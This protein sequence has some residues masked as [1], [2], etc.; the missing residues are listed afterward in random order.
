MS[1]GFCDDAQVF[2]VS[3][4][5]WLLVFVGVPCQFLQFFS[6]CYSLFYGCILVEKKGEFWLPGTCNCI[7]TCLWNIF[8]CFGPMYLIPC[9]LLLLG[10]LGQ[11]DS[12]SSAAGTT[13]SSRC[14]AVD[15]RTSTGPVVWRN[16]TK[17]TD[18]T[19]LQFCLEFYFY[20]TCGYIKSTSICMILP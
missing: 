1:F 12:R 6:F 2:V 8:S 3:I 16:S 14:P 11:E 7:F 5:L 4:I 15:T 19:C 9:F 17:W 18:F 10:I 13:T 20:L